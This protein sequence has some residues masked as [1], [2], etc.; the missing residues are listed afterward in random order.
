MYNYIFP[1]YQQISYIETA[2]TG[3][4]TKYGTGY[5]TQVARYGVLLQFS[6]VP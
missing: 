2:D 3:T 4:G 5:G 1:L 6:N